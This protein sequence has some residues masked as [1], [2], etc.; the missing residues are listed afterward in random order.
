MMV[1]YDVLAYLLCWA[2]MFLLRP[3]FEAPISNETGCLYL[4]L[5]LILF[6]GFRLVFSC[7]YCIFRYGR[8]YAFSREL[9]ATTLGA[10]TLVVL[11]RI[12]MMLTDLAKAPIV[13]MISFAGM[14]VVVSI[15]ARFV[16]YY[17]YRYAKESGTAFSQ[18]IRR[19]LNFFVFV[20]F[21]SEEPG[22]TRSIIPEDK[23]SAVFD[24]IN[25]LQRIIERFDIHGNVQTIKQI[26]K[27]YVNRT[28]KVE[29]LSEAGHIH[30]YILQRINTNVFPDVDALMHNFEVT[31]RHLHQRLR[32]PGYHKRGTVQTVRPTKNGDLY[33][34][35]DSGCWRMITYFDRVYSL[36]IPDTPEVFYYAGVS[37]G[38][39]VREMADI[40]PA[41]IREIIPNFHNTGSRYRDLEASISRDPRGRVKDVAPEIA[42][43][44]ARAGG[45][46]RISDA[47]ESGA[48]PTRICH[49]DCNLNNILFDMDSHLP[50][51]I[52]DLDTVMPSS[53][54]YDFGDS[55]RIGTNTAKDDEKD[56]S[57][58]RCDLGLYEQY[59][60]GY[61]KA[62]GHMLTKKELEL[63]PY[64]ALIITSEDGIRFL[65]D[66]IDGD[67]YYHIYYPGQNLDRSRTQLKL[68]SDMETKLPKIKEILRKIYAE[69]GLS[70][71]IV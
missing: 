4:F 44:R 3:S 51:A 39:F 61:L 15:M 14:Y 7:Y 22:A 63:L 18:L 46:S 13:F 9:L 30:K 16:Y 23:K 11:S 21:D 66:H 12:L 64:A 10:I 49:N 2:S 26:N 19:L 32:L 8:I 59:A 48:I 58:V 56:L 45:F 67:T 35:D 47:L 20:D 68:L 33:L 70:A 5:G 27:G 42:F 52:I 24:P 53:P 60:R 6:F 65:M 31:T 29:T 28:Y 40:D 54:L 37:F 1:F 17:L 38:S 50:V 57:K 34:R 41:E 43:I 69:L 25:D 71:E 62:C 55:M 36:D